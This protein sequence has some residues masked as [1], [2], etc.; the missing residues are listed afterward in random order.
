MK[1]YTNPY[2]FTILA[3]ALICFSSCGDNNTP[4]NNSK[5]TN[6]TSDMK[7][8]IESLLSQMTNAEKVALIHASSSFTSGGVER[9]GIP[10]LIMSDGPHGVRHEHGRDWD[11]EDIDTDKSTYLPTGVALASTWNTDLGYEFGAVLG[12]EAKFRGKDVILGPGLNIIR[13]PLAGRNFEYLTEDP[14][15]NAQMAVGYVKGVQD[16]GI[17]ACAKHYVANTYEYQRHYVDVLMDERA[18]RE[19]YL[20]G[21]KAVVQEADVLT[22]MGA[23]NKFRGTY[24]SHHPFLLDEVLRKEIGFEGLVISDWNA[25]KDSMEPVETS[26]DIEMGTDLSMLGQGLPLDY[27]KFHMGDALVEK[28]DKGEVDVALID[29]KVRRILEVMTR[30]NKFGERTAGA[31]NTKAHQAVAKQVADEAIVLLKNEDILPLEKEPVKKM[32]V[33]G[34]NATWKHAGAGGS[35]QVKA[36]YEITPMAG[37]KNLFGDDV[38]IDYAQGYDIKKDAV[39]TQEQIDEAVKTVTGADVALYV[40]GSFHGYS[41]EW[42]D[43]AYDA[44]DIDKPDMM[45][46]FGQDALLKAVLEA[47]PNTIVVLFGGA[48]VDMSEWHDKAKAIL[49]VWYPG[50]EG[51][52]SLANIIFGETNPS[53]KLPI[54]F[55]AKLEDSPAHS[56][57]SYPDENLIIDH[58]EGIMVGYRYFDTKNIKP[59]YAFG[60][61]L[62]YTT[63][64]FTGMEVRKN[65]ETVSV[66]LTVTNTG[67]MKGGEVVQIYVKDEVSSLV[68][69]EKELKAFKKVFLEPGEGQEVSFELDKSAFSYFDDKKMEW[70]LEPGKFIIMAGS[71]SDNIRVSGEIDM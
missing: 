29:S 40:G 71:A 56:V 6:T 28:L 68:R 38:V 60:H 66:S 18:F 64:D 61:G 39:A 1:I 2:L 65:G 32:A 4:A 8:D 10:E 53:G 31:Y 36:Y 57:S 54:T 15:L 46:P 35:S 49:Q 5:T 55:P 63:F 58:K 48:S 7:P 45:M 3:V 37:L 44:E 13:S 21:F 11:K 62:S 41:D 43:N 22:I 42:N 69:P 20:P 16:Q 24:C 19:I 34:A 33:V 9:L 50:M 52:N 12:R 30:I 23:Y 26:L 67:K 17:A 51:G 47:N 14:Y 59:A 70:V 25:V 27:S